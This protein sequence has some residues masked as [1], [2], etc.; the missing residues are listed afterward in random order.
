MANSFGNEAIN[1]IQVELVALLFVMSKP[2]GLSDD[3]ASVKFEVKMLPRILLACALACASAPAF[4]FS[5][6][7]YKD[8]TVTAYARK[9]GGEGSLSPKLRGVIALLRSQFGS[10]AVRN[11]GGARAGNV[12]GTRM[13]SCHNGGHAFDAHLS[14]AARRYVQGRKDLGVIT[15]SGRMHHVH[16]S[17][18]ARERGYRGHQRK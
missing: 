15:Y 11:V 13:A 3:K 4:A 12:A 8:R 7:V 10:S 5:W 9:A 2:V 18:C 1:P 17:D 14:A 6:S 16:V